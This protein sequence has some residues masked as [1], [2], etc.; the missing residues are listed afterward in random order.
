MFSFMG[1]SRPWRCVNWRPSAAAMLAAALFL[2]CAQAQ[3]PAQPAALPVLPALPVQH[4]AERLV[5]HLNGSIRLIDE[6]A[7]RMPLKQ[8][9]PV[10][11]QA[12]QQHPELRLV[13]AQV[14]RTGEART[15]AFAAFLP[16]ISANVEGGSRQL[17]AQVYPWSSLPAREQKSQGYGLTVRQLL[18]DFGQTSRRVGAQEA[19]REAAEHRQAVRRSELSLRAL[20][21]WNQVFRAQQLVLLNAM[22]VVARTQIRSFVEEREQMGGSSRSDVL[23]VQARI[24]EAEIALVAAENQLRAA[25]AAYFEI[26]NQNPPAAVAL[27]EAPVLPR[28][29]FAGGGAVLDDSLLLRE[30]RALGRQYELEAQA[31]ASALYPRLTLE[32]SRSR[33]DL[34]SGGTPG[35]DSAF[36][37]VGNQNLYAGGADQ[38]RQRQAELRS[39]ESLLE[40]DIR[41]RQ[42]DKLVSELLAELDNGEASLKARRGG[43]QGAMRALE[44]VR[45]Q[46]FFRRGAL[47]DLLRAQEELFVAGRELIVGLVEHAQVRYRLLH[48]SGQLD[49]VLQAQAAPVTSKP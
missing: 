16:Q 17:G 14:E 8:L 32:V 47:L 3:A 25:Q 45:E 49:E 42:L 37:I 30:L 22:N 48:V 29:R 46:F 18:Y 11:I 33:R 40:L 7:L 36:A 9:A 19:A 5:Q 21:A 12:A 28:E 26:Y 13:G 41:R 39:Q 31:A 10:V 24:A 4:L 38:A 35:T 2:P 1:R 20:D 44:V 15:E 34:Y 43:V 23:R 27:L 6:P